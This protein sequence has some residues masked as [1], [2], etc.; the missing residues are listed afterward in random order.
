MDSGYAVAQAEAAFDN[1]WVLEDGVTITPV[2]QLN[3]P[4][5]S[6]QL[7]LRSSDPAQLNDPAQFTVPESKINASGSQ[8]SSMFQRCQLRLLYISTL[9]RSP[10]MAYCV[11][12]PDWIISCWCFPINWLWYSVI[13]QITWRYLCCSNATQ[14]SAVLL[15]TTTTPPSIHQC[16]VSLQTSYVPSTVVAAHLSCG[17]ERHETH[18]NLSVTFWE[19]LCTDR[20]QG[21]CEW[22]RDCNNIQDS[23]TLLFTQYYTT[24]TDTY[25]HLCYR[26]PASVV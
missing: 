20:R 24:F 9:S 3:Q 21:R 7:T 10:C 5:I 15:A 14:I 25:R 6:P 23:Q 26:P 18:C 2:N 16:F 1:M 19:A 11:M 8:H 17:F 22:C 4:V 13:L 12:K